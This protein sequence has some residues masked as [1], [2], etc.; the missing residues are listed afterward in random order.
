V[1]F[2]LTLVVGGSALALGAAQLRDGPTVDAQPNQQATVRCPTGV[3][4]ASVTP[5]TIRVPLGGSI[6]WRMQGPVTSD[7]IIISPK[8]PDQ[9]WPFAGTPSRGGSSARASNAQRRGQYSYNVD[10]LCRINGVVT[11]VRIDPDIIIE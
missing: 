3:N 11:P 6:D 8:D 1:K 10:L 9:A 7:S 5:D 2:M 4:P